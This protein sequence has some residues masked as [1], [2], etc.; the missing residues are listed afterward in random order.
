MEELVKV[1]AHNLA[2]VA[3]CLAI[4]F[5]A[6]GMVKGVVTWVREAMIA[7]RASDA[8]LH[9]RRD[10]GQMLSLGLE[11]LIGADILMT[12]IA[13]SWT[14]LGHLATIVVI[15]TTLNHFLMKELEAYPGEPKA[16]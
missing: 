2:L 16:A 1:V 15:R 11:F 6:I 9:I 7:R 5:I 3:E 8:V 10:L 14:E 13:P 12:A 4:M